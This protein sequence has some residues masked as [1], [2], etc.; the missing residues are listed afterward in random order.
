MPFKLGVGDV[1]LRIIVTPDAIRVGVTSVVFHAR[2]PDHVREGHQALLPRN[3]GALSTIKL[4]PSSKELLLQ[5][6][7]H[8]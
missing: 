8:C 2:I 3:D 5:L 4:L 7:N 6:D 1:H